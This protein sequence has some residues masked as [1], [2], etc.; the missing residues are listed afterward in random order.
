MRKQYHLRRS[1]RGTLAWDVD[2]LIELSKNFTPK[3][4][5]LS[6]I[7]ELDQSFWFSDGQKATCREIALH[8]KLMNET[9]LNFPIILSQDGAV[10]DGM[11]RVCKALI[12]GMGS[13]Q[14]V[15]FRADPEPDF[16]G[17]EPDDLPY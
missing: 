13:I 7:R 10:M 15:Q 14:A 17:V 11:H 3:S 5:L 6:D 2:R 1:D 12:L 4:V 16:I 9:D 8:A